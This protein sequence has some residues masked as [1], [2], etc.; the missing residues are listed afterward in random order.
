MSARG[1]IPLLGMCLVAAPA[2]A[3]DPWRLPDW[4]ARAV[5]EIPTPSSE[6]GVDAAGVKIL[7]Q[8]RARSDGADYRILD[9]DGKAVSFQLDFHDPDHYTLLTFKVD[10]PKQRFYVYFGNPKATRAAE[11]TADFPAPGGGPPSGGWV[12]HCGF[13]YQTID[14][15]R[16]D[17]VA[18]EHD[19]DNIDEMAKLI[20]ASKAKEGARWQRR[21]ADGYNPFGSSD[22]YISVYRGWV[23]APKAGPYQFCTV[24]NKASF[25]FLDGKPLIHWPGYHTVERGMHGEVNAKVE[26]TAGLHYLEYYHETTPLEHMAYLGWRP[27]GDAGNFSPIPETFYTAP[28]AAVVMAYE[29]V[30]G[31]LLHFEPAITDSVWPVER[32][33][34][35]YT[36][37]HFAAGKTPPLPDGTKCHWDFGDGQGADGAEADHVYLTLG[38]FRV[39]L[40]AQGPTGTQTALWPLSVFEIEHVTDQFKEGRPKD[41]ASLA[42]GYERGKL[43]ADALQE[44]QHL[45]AEGGQP[46]ESVEVGKTFLQRFPNS[47]PLAQARVR[48][49]MADCA[50]RMGQG[51]LDEAIAEYE[52]ALVKE[53]PP[54]ETLDVLAR[55]IRLVGVE[56]EQPEKAAP[57]FTRAEAAYQSAKGI[58]DE[59]EEVRKA[60]RRA[61]IAMGD[62]RLWQG[63]LDDAREVYAR[64]E[65]LGD[66]IPPQVRAARLGAFPDSLQEYLDSGN[67]GAAL[68]L[69]DKWDE[70]FPTDKP[71][72]HSLFWRGKVLTARSQPQEAARC[73]DRAVRLTT[74]AP[75]ETEARW[76]LADALEQLGRKDEAKRELAKLVAIGINDKFTKKAIEKLKQ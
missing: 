5:V 68:D 62:V 69:V 1:W 31:P 72:G 17:D 29:D 35:Q 41:Y 21:V 67:T 51:S 9:A 70:K 44:L 66:F 36:R 46:A 47:E 4:S 12:P 23:R 25:S 39:T 55:L 37:V 57:V 64:A 61:L 16:A 40:T 76:M 73:L 28:H 32:D 56:R 50:V 33:Q 48:R 60:Y 30:K 45:L 2:V 34:G 43:A 15:P 38:S 7:C 74:G 24:S 65:K 11:Q 75:F 3:A 49:L 58:A 27:S 20:A 14:R 63:K 18:K 71:N 53:T 19:P 42:K 54:A 10:N 8:G 22:Y 26:L 13:V 6:E 52:A 59:R